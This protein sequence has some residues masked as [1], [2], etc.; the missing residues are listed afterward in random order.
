MEFANKD[1]AKRFECLA[2]ADVIKN[3]GSYS[4][5]LSKIDMATA[6]FLFK[7]GDT[8]I[9]EKEKPVKPTVTAPA[10]TK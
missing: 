5:P 8:S 7:S 4:G 9:K 1:V 6:E 2:E 3:T 10:A